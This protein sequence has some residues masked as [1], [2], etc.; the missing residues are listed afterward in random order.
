[1]SSICG[2]CR[3]SEVRAK[4]CLQLVEKA[5]LAP[6]LSPTSL[7]LLQPPTRRPALSQTTHRPNLTSLPSPD[8]VIEHTGSYGS[9]RRSQSRHSLCLQPQAP[10]EGHDRSR[11]VHVRPYNTV[12]S[13]KKEKKE[14]RKADNRTTTTGKPTVSATS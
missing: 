1:M 10:P 8:L 3:I 6:R 12:H 11:H 4:T 2:L 13:K 7:R 5:V 14:K 9:L